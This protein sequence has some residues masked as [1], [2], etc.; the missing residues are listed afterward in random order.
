MKR[1]RLSVSK[2]PL[3]KQKVSCQTETEECS[4]HFQPSSLC[5]RLLPVPYKCGVIGTELHK[6]SIGKQVPDRAHCQDHK[7]MHLSRVLRKPVQNSPGSS[8]SFSSWG[9]YNALF[10][11]GTCSL[12]KKKPTSRPSFLCFRKLGLAIPISPP[13]L[14]GS[15]FRPF[16]VHF[17]LALL[18]S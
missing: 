12:P 4:L 5:S 10:T 3:G 6:H 17:P 8:H 7:R 11:P 1:Y 14:L 15:L 9:T 2:F 16:N 13:S 18:V